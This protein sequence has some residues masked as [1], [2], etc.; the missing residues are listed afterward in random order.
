MR[1]LKE[2]EYYRGDDI[3][4]PFVLKDDNEQDIPFKKGD[5]ITF[6]AKNNVYKNEYALYKEF[7]LDKDCSELR[8]EFTPE[9]TRKLDITKYLIELE[10]I[11]NGK[12][13]TVFQQEIEIIGDVVDR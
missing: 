8:I 13:K 10:L 4:F 3:E 1:E 2:N 12:T 5:N 9:E 6:G 7:V 11:R